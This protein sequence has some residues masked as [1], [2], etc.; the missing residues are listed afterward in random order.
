MLS[1]FPSP[2]CDCGSCTIVNGYNKVFVFN[3]AC[4]GAALVHQ[5]WIMV[6]HTRGGFIHWVR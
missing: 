5:I 6:G 2:D 1:L 3:A 4:S